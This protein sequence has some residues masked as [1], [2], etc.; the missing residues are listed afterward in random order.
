MSGIGLLNHK[1][2][3]SPTKKTCGNGLQGPTRKCRGTQSKLPWYD[4]S[5]SRKCHRTA[6][7]IHTRASGCES[8]AAACARALCCHCARVSDFARDFTERPG[9]AARLAGARDDAAL[10]RCI[11]TGILFM[12]CS[13]QSFHIYRIHLI[14]SLAA[15][16]IPSISLIPLCSARTPCK[17]GQDARLAARR[18]S[19]AMQDADHPCISDRVSSGVAVIPCIS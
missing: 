9:D 3:G 12:R 14:Y 13:D 10:R 16:H 2:N 1:P 19:R 18:G 17:F 11:S 7:S 4:P 8:C 15:A 6:Q 5:F